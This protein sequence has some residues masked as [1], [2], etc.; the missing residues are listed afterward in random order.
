MNHVQA[1]LTGGGK[2]VHGGLAMSVCHA[3]E[4]P[5]MRA[6][7]VWTLLCRGATTQ[8]HFM[9]PPDAPP[10]HVL[11]TMATKLRPRF[12]RLNST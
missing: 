11:A 8:T 2:C 10:T 12:V 9:A 6:L 1:L 5:V 3:R 4:C 7:C